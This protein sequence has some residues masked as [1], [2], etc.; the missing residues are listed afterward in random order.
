MPYYWFVICSH[1]KSILQNKKNYSI[2]LTCHF[3]TYAVSLFGH[4]ATKTQPRTLIKGCAATNH[5]YNLL[6]THLDSNFSA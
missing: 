5:E 6:I 3:T 2:S 1:H 4:C